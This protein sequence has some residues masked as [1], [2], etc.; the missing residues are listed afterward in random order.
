MNTYTFSSSCDCVLHTHRALLGIVGQ[1]AQIGAT[2]QG[3]HFSIVTKRSAIC[4]CPCWSGLP[5]AH[6][7][8]MEGVSSQIFAREAPAVTDGQFWTALFTT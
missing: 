2:F 1:Y 3:S 8:H 6:S 4:C 7:G 5:S